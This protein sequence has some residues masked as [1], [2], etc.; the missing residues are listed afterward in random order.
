MFENYKTFLKTKVYLDY[1][2][3]EEKKE[4]VLSLVKQDLR[5]RLLDI[6]RELQENKP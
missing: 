3:K 1:K 5:Y 2:V 4:K 6:T